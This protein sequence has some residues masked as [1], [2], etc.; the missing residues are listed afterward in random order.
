M[1]NR[2]NPARAVKILHAHWPITLISALGALLVFTN[3]G[4]DYLWEDEG[5]TAALA[6]NILKF[7]VPK[8]WD[9]GAF[10]DSDHGARLNRD[11]VMVTHPWIQYYLSAASFLVFGENTFAARIPFAIAGWM[12]ILFVYLFVWRLF[13]N[14][15]TAFSAAALLVFSVQFLF[16]AKQSRYCALNMLLVVWLFWSFFKMKSA[17]DCVLFI[18]ASVFLFHTHPYGIAPVVALGALSL[19]YR[20]F[21]IQRRWILFATPAIALLTLP[22]LALSSLSSSRSALNTTAAQSAGEFIERCAQAFIE[23]T[24][25]TPLI[26]RIILF[27][28]AALSIRWKRKDTIDAAPSDSVSAEQQVAPRF[29]ETNE[30]ALLLSALLTIVFYGLA[31]AITQSSDSLW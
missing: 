2:W 27:L 14:R 29:F 16:Y 18:L 23:S 20:P 10:L 4:S 26:G 25:V 12:S 19:I 13:G 7:G 11:L 28:V 31:T 9:G 3:L 24:S 6:S 1:I 15:L 30:T 22:W 21:V 8:A 17:R 5:D